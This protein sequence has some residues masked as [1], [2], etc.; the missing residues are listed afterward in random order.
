MDN[1]KVLSALEKGADSARN[2]LRR[3]FANAVIN[4]LCSIARD[5]GL[6]TKT[7]ESRRP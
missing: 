1:R 3:E 2:G 6:E 7:I 5:L 4:T